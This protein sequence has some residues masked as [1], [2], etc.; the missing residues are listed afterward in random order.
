MKPLDVVPVFCATLVRLV[1]KLVVSLLRLSE[2]E[3]KPHGF[4]RKSLVS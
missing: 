2:V 4:T 1:R 3:K